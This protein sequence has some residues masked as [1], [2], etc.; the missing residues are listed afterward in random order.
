MAMPR[1]ADSAQ[2]R[3]CLSDPVRRACR[4]YC[5]QDDWSKTGCLTCAGRQMPAMRTSRREN[6]PARD[7]PAR[8]GRRKG[9]GSSENELTYLEKDVAGPQTASSP[10]V[11]ESGGVNRTTSSTHFRQTWSY[12]Q[13]L[14][15]GTIN[16]VV[17]PHAV[18]HATGHV[19]RGS[20]SGRAPR[21][22]SLTK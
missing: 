12:T 20:S 22:C 8:C 10:S 7:L 14:A 19:T 5:C 16:D 6:R 1:L 13:S 2:V 15:A 11:A 18:A 21:Y 4:N 17:L 9:F 3:H